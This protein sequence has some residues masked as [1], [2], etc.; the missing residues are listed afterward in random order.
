[1]SDLDANAVLKAIGFSED[2]IKAINEGGTDALAKEVDSLKSKQRDNYRELLKLDPEFT[3]TF[4]DAGYKRAEGKLKGTRDNAIKSVFGV[5]ISELSG[6]SFQDKLKDAREKFAK[7]GSKDKDELND[8]II[9]LNK[10][11]EESGNSHQSVIDN[12][13]A[14][15]ANE[16]KDILFQM[17]LSE[18]V[19]SY[20][21]PEGQE[22]LGNP[23]ILL[24][25]LRNYF[26]GFTFTVDPALSGMSAVKITDKEGNEV[27]NSK[28]D[29][30]LT[31]SGLF[32]QALSESGML[33]EKEV[34]KAGPNGKQPVVITSQ[35]G[36]APKVKGVDPAR[37]AEMK[38]LREQ[39]EKKNG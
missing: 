35:G 2:S 17:K 5:D 24:P 7:S 16:R 6:D 4:E 10:K 1:M 36:E 25:Y 32:S 39:L 28:G 20:Q 33:K 8:Q 37:V 13:K 30:K 38:A 26:N 23:T 9:A 22:L 34:K 15:F 27:L 11:I 3:K 19:T 21:A 18:A 29:G 31:A 12:L 14:E